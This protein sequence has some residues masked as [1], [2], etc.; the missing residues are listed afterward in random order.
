MTGS[1]NTQPSPLQAIGRQVQVRWNIERNDITN[2]EGIQVENWTYEYANIDNESKPAITEAVL[3]AR[4][5]QYQVESIIARYLSGDDT[6]QYADYLRTINIAEAVSE[7]KYFK[8]ELAAF[9]T[10]EV[11][12]VLTD[13]VTALNDK[14]IIP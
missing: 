1:S 5:S 6:G 4:Y 14:G 3:R 10:A 7:G 8:S 2:E 11:S 13:L 9:E 12:D